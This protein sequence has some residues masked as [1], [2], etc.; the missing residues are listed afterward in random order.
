MRNLLDIYEAWDKN[1]TDYIDDL[2]EGLLV[3]Q[4]ALYH[5]NQKLDLLDFLYFLQKDCL[6]INQHNTHYY[7]FQK[8]LL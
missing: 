8:F 3:A 5:V 6:K 4:E 7:F 2:E 1:N